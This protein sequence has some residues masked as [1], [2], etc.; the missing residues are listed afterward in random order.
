MPGYGS[1]PGDVSMA[2]H[3]YQ[4]S[5][6]GHSSSSTGGWR[7]F[8][9][10][11]SPPKSSAAATPKAA[12]VAV[13]GVAAGANGGSTPP[14]ASPMTPTTARRQGSMDVGAVWGPVASSPAFAKMLAERPAVNTVR[15]VVL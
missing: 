3:D 1:M 6:P 11:S 12:A 14:L 13:P 4:G 2:G 8:W 10:A 15:W 7:S 5:M 9:H